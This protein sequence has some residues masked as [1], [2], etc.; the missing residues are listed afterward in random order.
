MLYDVKLNQL[1][2]YFWMVITL[3][4]TVLLFVY[5]YSENRL[6]FSFLIPLIG[7]VSWEI[8]K[9]YGGREVYYYPKDLLNYVVENAT[10]FGIYVAVHLL[11][12]DKYSTLQAVYVVVMAAVI[13]FNTYAILKIH[14]AAN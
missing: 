10:I 2:R 4:L 3:I 1:G 13:I 14:R 7:I 5:S 9:R 8:V 12:K 6:D 11:L